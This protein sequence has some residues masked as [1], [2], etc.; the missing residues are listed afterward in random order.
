[1]SKKY[2]PSG[3][4]IINIDASDK[5]AGIPFDAVTEDEKLLLSFLQYGSKKPILLELVDTEGYYWKGYPTFFN[6]ALS[7]SYGAVG[8]STTV[9]ISESSGQLAINTIEE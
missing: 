2:V 8:T 3:Y 4:Q 6:S 1:M 5:T 7:L 9:I